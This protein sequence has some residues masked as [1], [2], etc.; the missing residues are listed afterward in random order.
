VLGAA[1]LFFATGAFFFFELVGSFLF[2]LDA[3]LAAAA[4][5]V[6][7]FPIWSCATLRY[8]LLPYGH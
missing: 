2:L 1:F 5:L 8:S 3:L 6:F 4:A 7:C